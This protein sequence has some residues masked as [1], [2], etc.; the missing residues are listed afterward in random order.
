MNILF[1]INSFSLGGAEK[2]VYDLA[3]QLCSQVNHISI[4][5][6]YKNDLPVE[7]QMRGK[8]NKSG[9]KTYILDKRAKKDR[10]KSV[11]QIY[12]IIKQDK[13]SIVHAH[14]GVPMLLGKLA[15]LLAHVPVVCTVHSTRDYSAKQERLSSWMSRSYVAI[16]QAAERYM[17]Q[18]LHIP[19]KRITRIY[20]AVDTNLFRPKPKKPDFWKS[21]GGQSGDISLIHVG[22]VH[23]AKNQLCMLRALNN[24]KKQGLTNYKLYIIGPYE[25]EDSVYKEI[26][27]FIADNELKKQV[28]L[29]GPKEDVSAFL[30]NADCF[31]MTS[32]YEGLSLA[33][34]EAVISGLPVITT[35][36]E[37][38]QNLNR[39]VPCA[40]IIPPDDAGA[41]ADVLKNKTFLTLTPPRELFAKQFS[42]ET[43]AQKHL[44]LYR[45]CL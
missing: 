42:I 28:Y 17:T 21:Y 41:L 29:L 31:L 13:I 22:R 30:I 43:C 16:G 18:Q 15:G 14:C 9:I 4:I 20:N 5:G 45:K 26:I 11:W 34:L 3:L 23:E 36:L 32:R 33:F 35:D 6:L 8:L 10:L 37:F 39:I 40:I 7:A 27:K 38:V 12:K 24:L 19:A 44:E 1:I 2:L 25:Q